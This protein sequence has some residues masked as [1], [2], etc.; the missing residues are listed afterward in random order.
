MK[1]L[2]LPYIYI[3]TSLGV[4]SFLLVFS[5]ASTENQELK[6]ALTGAWNLRSIY[7]NDFE[8][9]S[10]LTTTTLRLNDGYAKL[11]TLIGDQLL[12]QGRSSW[13]IIDSTLIFDNKKSSLAGEYSVCFILLDAPDHLNGFFIMELENDEFSLY[14][15]KA[16]INPEIDFAR[17]KNEYHKYACEVVEESKDV[18]SFH[19]SY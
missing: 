7:K 2:K 6:E 19:Q 14:L 15:T 18:L 16:H 9:T 13:R 17:Y 4:L 11:P 12:S 8:A 10:E 5:L 1:S 3:F